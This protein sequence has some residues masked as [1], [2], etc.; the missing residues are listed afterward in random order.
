MTKWAVVFLLFS[1][2]SPQRTATMFGPTGTV[3]RAHIIACSGPLQ[4]LADCYYKV[5]QICGI[6]GYQT[7]MTVDKPMVMSVFGFSLTPFTDRKVVVECR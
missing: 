6:S 2:C 3:P 5:G 4:D 1:A 7:V